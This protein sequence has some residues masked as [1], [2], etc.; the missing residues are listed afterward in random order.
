MLKINLCD[1]SSNAVAERSSTCHYYYASYVS[2][3]WTLII[4]CSWPYLTNPMCDVSI[5]AL[6]S[7]DHAKPSRSCSKHWPRNDECGAISLCSA[8]SGY[9]SPEVNLRDYPCVIPCEMVAVSL[10]KYP[11]T[12]LMLLESGLAQSKRYHSMYYVSNSSDV[13]LA[14]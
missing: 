4:I 3:E 12:W 13:G 1:G 2:K 5:P 14:T 6:L 8:R 7:I 11:I 9:P 10:L